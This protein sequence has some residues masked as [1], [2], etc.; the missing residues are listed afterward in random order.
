MLDR[1]DDEVATL[2][3]LFEVL[4]W[5]Q[6][7]LHAKPVLLLN[8]GGYWAPLLA[9]LDHILAHDFAEAAF[10]G[11]LETVDGVPALIERLGALLAEKEIELITEFKVNEV[12]GVNGVVRSSDD[13]HTEF[14]L[15]VTV[16]LHGGATFVERS[17]PLGNALGFVPTNKHTL[18]HESAANIFALGDATDLPVSKA[19]SVTQF[20]AEVLTDNV[21]R[22]LEGKK[23]ER[24]YDTIVEMD[25]D[26]SHR[27]ADLQA[28]LDRA[29]S[30]DLVIGSR[31]VAGGEVVN[32]PWRRKF[33][34]VN[35]NR[36]VR[37][38]MGLKVHDATA[39]FRAYRAETLASLDLESVESQGYC[40]Q[41][42]MTWRVIQA[43]GRVQEVPITF[44]ERELGVSKMS[45]SI[46]REALVKVTIWGAQR[47]WRQITGAE[48]RAAKAARKA[49]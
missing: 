8:V 42:D 1:K 21:V 31:W 10:R 37:L 40:F 30:A 44:V 24:G 35:A 39:G 29:H 46:I 28:L 27:A 14:D 18:R 20:E 26:G 5:R 7:G 48:R 17:A 45:G 19:G 6:L 36:Y 41:V 43:G 38:A 2:D 32:W 23:L 47:R 33:L 9:L 15:F 49:I 11:Y 3:E 4:T 12:D 13:R 16:P 34:S 25:A 22:H